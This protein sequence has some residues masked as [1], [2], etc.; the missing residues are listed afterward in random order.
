MLNSDEPNVTDVNELLNS[1][2]SASP[3]SLLHPLPLSEAFE[4]TINSSH[5]AVP[6]RVSGLLQGTL[7]QDFDPSLNTVATPG[8]RYIQ[9]TGSSATDVRP[10]D[11]TTVPDLEPDVELFAKRSKRTGQGGSEPTPRNSEVNR[12]AQKKFRQ[13]QKVTFL[14]MRITAS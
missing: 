2:I 12:R 8:V 6:P 1:W 3:P 9:R 14:G 11:Q 4:G 10:G 7:L 5:P 13:K